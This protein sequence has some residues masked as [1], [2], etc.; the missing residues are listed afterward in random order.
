MDVVYPIPTKAVC[1]IRG[2]RE[3]HST[4]VASKSKPDPQRA[5]LDLGGTN[6]SICHVQAQKVGH[7]SFQTPFIFK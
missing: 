6:S 1:R 2:E 5:L 4:Q 3:P 7:A